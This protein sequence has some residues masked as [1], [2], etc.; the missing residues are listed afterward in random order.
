LSGSPTDLPTF[1]SA[2]CRHTQAI[3][4]LLPTFFLKPDHDIL[5]AVSICG[6]KFCAVCELGVAE[7]QS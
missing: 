5:K 1:S 7:C 6:C 4:F 2:Q 3:H